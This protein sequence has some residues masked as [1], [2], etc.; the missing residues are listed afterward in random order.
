[1]SDQKIQGSPAGTL[2]ISDLRRVGLH[3]LQVAVG[4]AAAALL[5][6]VSGAELGPVKPFVVIGVTGLV[7]LVRRWVSDTQAAPVQ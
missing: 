1:M 6:I 4:A 7:D 5:E 3:L 2:R